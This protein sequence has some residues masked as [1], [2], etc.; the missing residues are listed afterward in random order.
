MMFYSF[1]PMI[2]H[3]AR[4]M[5]GEN[6]ERKRKSKILFEA[7]EIL[8]ELEG[9]MD[10]QS[11]P[12]ALEFLQ[13][14]GYPLPSSA[15]EGLRKYAEMLFFRERLLKALDANSGQEIAKFT[16]ASAVHR[17]TGKYH[18]R[19]VSA[20]VGAIRNDQNYDETSHRV[21]RIRTLP[22]LNRTVSPLPII[23][24]ALNVVLKEGGATD[25]PN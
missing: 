6:R 3:V 2:D 18:D 9:F 10:A 5:F 12:S 13:E 19:E 17:I 1:S 11:L 8:K 20:I 22:R 7:I 23:L 21:W 4:S 15:A 25:L 14:F 24:Y 16:L